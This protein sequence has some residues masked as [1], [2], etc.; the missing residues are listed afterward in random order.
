M[1][2]VWP[3]CP[4]LQKLLLL[5]LPS[6]HPGLTAKVICGLAEISWTWGCCPLKFWNPADL[7]FSCEN[8]CFSVGC[9]FDVV[10]CGEAS[11]C[12]KRQSWKNCSWIFNTSILWLGAHF[13]RRKKTL[14]VFFPKAKS[15]KVLPSGWGGC[16]GAL[17]FWLGFVG[18]RSTW[19]SNRQSSGILELIWKK[20]ELRMRVG[21]VVAPRFNP[22]RGEESLGFC[23]WSKTIELIGWLASALWYVVLL[24]KGGVKK[25]LSHLQA[26]EGWSAGLC[27]FFFC[28]YHKTCAKC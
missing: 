25:F 14:R 6:A 15:G 23:M 24:C 10:T 4:N 20:L 12:H 7:C 19:S 8:P 11:S 16:C 1:S 9:L 2:S 27:V 21:A 13:F 18:F 22:C 28:L 26:C 5:N 17:R 3:F